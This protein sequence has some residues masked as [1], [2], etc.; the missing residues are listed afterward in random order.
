VDYG[1]KGP[2]PT[3]S[4]SSPA[5][6]LIYRPMVL[7]EKARRHP[8]IVWGNGTGT[9]TATVYAGFFQQW[10]SH[11]FI[12]AAANTPNAGTSKEMLACL[13][14]VEAQDAVAGS[15][16]EGH[17]ALD[18]AG[19]SGHSQGG[20]GAIMAGRDDRV[21]ATLPFQPYTLGLGH[22]IASQSQQH[23]PMFMVSGTGDFIATPAQNQA[24]VFAA[25]NVPTFWGTLVGGDHVT[26]ALGSVQAYLAPST[27]WWLLQLAH[28][29]NARSMF[30]GSACT[31]CSD[32]KW[33]VMQKQL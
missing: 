8:V 30:Y 24:P 18:R 16:Y 4:E 11:G 9:P 15:P 5:D 21:I 33:Q 10:A 17:V 31:L 32:T 3:V 2:F 12:V 19:A 25:S 29:E 22:D 14:W 27:A 23:G 28:D 1:G 13:D 20:G 6:C 7:G 26:I